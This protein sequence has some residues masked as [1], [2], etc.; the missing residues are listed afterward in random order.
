MVSRA[1]F[2][3][4]ALIGKLEEYFRRRRLVHVHSEILLHERVPAGTPPSPCPCCGSE[5]AGIVARAADLALLI[6]RV[7]GTRVERWRLGAE[8][9]TEF[10]RLTAQAEDAYIPLRCTADQRQLLLTNAMVTMAS[11][12]S[13]GGKTTTA[14]SWLVRRWMLRGGRGHKF[15][16]VA[17]TNDIAFTFVD[18][19]IRGVG[20]APP[21][22]PT[23]PDGTPSALVI[24]FPESATSRDLRVRLIDGSIIILR[25][26]AEKS[27]KALKSK[28]VYDT[29]LDEGAEMKTVDQW[30]LLLNRM[31]DHPGAQI[32]V[33]TTPRPKHFLKKEVVDKAANGDPDYLELPLSMR[34]NP[35]FDQAHVQRIIDKQPTAA[36]VAREVDGRW[37]SD[38]GMLWQHWDQERFVVRPTAEGRGGR[39]LAD[40]TAG[41]GRTMAPL[42]ITEAVVRE[43]FKGPNPYVDR[44]LIENYTYVAGQDFNVQP[45]TTVI[46]QVQAEGCCP[47]CGSVALERY[48]TDLRHLR[49]G[50]CRHRWN[51]SAPKYR[52][53]CTLWI[54]DEVVTGKTGR[55][56]DTILHCERIN[57][58][59]LAKAID[60]SLQESPYSRIAV[61]CD[62]EGAYNDP[63]GRRIVK[64]LK[65]RAPCAA[66]TMAAHGFDARAPWCWEASDKPRN[67]NIKNSVEQMHALMRDGRLRIHERCQNLLHSIREQEADAQ[68][69][70]LKESGTASDRLSSAIDALRYLCWAVFG[71]LLDSSVTIEGGTFA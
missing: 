63:T 26:L 8:D 71:P 10:D 11:G 31:V 58:L 32:F 41:P 3:D 9:L 65:R 44:T 37:A 52:Q 27:G 59:E 22:L 5:L 38:G 68:G 25:H 42:D 17:P 54:W 29:L 64:Y 57:S 4:G 24:S 45:M 12:G 15:F 46:G 21:I 60:R 23:R 13:R 48:T 2:E 43:F 51:P 35:W 28:D 50:D 62:G 49:C 34:R 16:Y 56:T 33:S 14:I 40:I 6:D 36:A 70:P 66:E 30:S 39:K 47:A 55:G 69:L 18:K 20:I 19:L 53:R 7:T 61:V 67:P 1:Q